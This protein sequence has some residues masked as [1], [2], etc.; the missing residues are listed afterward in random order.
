MKRTQQERK[1]LEND[2]EQDRNSLRQCMREKEKKLE[3]L[4]RVYKQNEKEKVR[5]KRI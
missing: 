3:V 4:M 5:K 1:R 2:K